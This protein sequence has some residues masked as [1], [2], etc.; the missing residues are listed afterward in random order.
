MREV[1]PGVYTFN[2]RLTRTQIESTGDKALLALYLRAERYGGMGCLNAVDHVHEFAAPYFEGKNVAN[3]SLLDID[4]ALLRLELSTAKRRGKITGDTSQEDKVRL[5]QRKQNLG[6]NAILSI[7][8]AL[9][10]GVAHVRGQDLY[11]FLREELL[12]I[13]ERL[14][15]AHGVAI[16]G[17]R[18]DDY[19][20]ALRE[21]N[22]NLEAQSLPLYAALREVTGIYRRHEE[23]A[24]MPVPYIP[25]VIPVPDEEESFS[26]QEHEH[27]AA[28]NQ[29]LLASYGA[30][31]NADEHKTTLRRYLQTM[32]FLGQRHR[33]FEIAN[34]RIFKAGDTLI[35]PYDAHGKLTIYLL[36]ESSEQLV[37]QLRL[38]HGSLI[39]DE[40]VAELA[41][42]QGEVID[43]ELEIYHLEVDD[44][45]AIQVARLRDLA[46]LLRRLNAVAAAMKRC[47][48]CVSWWRA[49]AAPR[50][51]ACPAARTCERDRAR[52]SASWLNS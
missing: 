48:C 14:A 49:C 23:P 10:R 30:L 29:S 28:L 44:M 36:R 26:V 6:M 25:P 15:A 16:P 37:T 41:G 9:A 2:T 18:F 13:I 19:L 11:E 43:L 40:F 42:M 12:V 34:H 33:M 4:R 46:R 17:S 22:T 50:T 27:I 3:W 35:V 51:A 8:L 5:M 20:A 1:E 21:V 7:S 38:P 45:P 32:T 47:T 52:T 39:T 24:A 31:G